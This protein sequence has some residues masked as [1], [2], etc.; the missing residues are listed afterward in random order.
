MLEPLVVPGSLAGYADPDLSPF[1]LIEAYLRC[2][3]DAEASALEARPSRP[4]K[5]VPGRRP[6]F[7]QVRASSPG[8]DWEALCEREPLGIRSDR[9]RVRGGAHGTCASASCCGA[10]GAAAPRAEPLARALATFERLG[11]KP[12]ADR[13][14]AGLRAAGLALSATVVPGSARDRLTERERQVVD[15]AAH[16][17]TNKEIAASSSSALRTVELHLSAAFRKLGIRRRSELVG[18]LGQLPRGHRARERDT[19]GLSPRRGGGRSRGSP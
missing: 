10:I 5:G 17:R 1:D 7:A 16:G 13:A 19:S 4:S 3:R 6:R 8:A 15:A 11:A 2:G 9:L 12:W 18:Q 14:R